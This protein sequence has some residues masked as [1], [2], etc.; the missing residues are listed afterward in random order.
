RSQPLEVPDTR[1][2]DPAAEWGRLRAAVAAVR[3]EV[4]QVRARTAWRSGEADAEIFDAH[5]LLLDDAELLG[6][7]RA[8]WEA[9]QAA[10]PAW[11]AAMGRVAAEL[12]RLSDPYL[13]AR[14][15][16]VRAVGDQVLR[17]LLGGAAPAA[18]GKGA[19]RE[20]GKDTSQGV[21]VAADLTPAEAAELA[22]GSV[23]AVVLA[24]GSPTAHGAILAR[25]RG[26][27][28]VVGAGP[29]VLDIADGT[30]LAVDGGSGEV[31]AG[32]DG[33]TLA[34][35]RDRAAAQAR[36]GAAALAGAAAPAV[37]RD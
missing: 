3:S 27:P 18:A 1:A 4:Q 15:A 23:D 26:I 8:R 16:D 30:V 11:A 17:A 14:A 31:V 34:R 37:T 32:P 28:M 9:G 35:F 10:A 2:E 33:P 6:E 22:P 7:V 25:G 20:A 19:G 21:L 5:L 13:R 29:A 12:A 24:F 36:A